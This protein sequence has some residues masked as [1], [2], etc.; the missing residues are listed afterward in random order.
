MTTIDKPVPS[1][2]STHRLTGMN[3]H[4][5]SVDGHRVNVFEAGDGPR[6]IMLVPGIPDSS[7]V[8]RGQVTGLLDAGYRVIAPDLLGQGDSDM[9][10]GA[11]HYT[12]AR[13]QERLWAVADALGARTFHLVGHDRGAY[14]TWAMAAKRPDRVESLVALSTGHPGARQQSGYEQRQLSWYMLRLQFPD[15]EQW[16]RGE[17]EGEGGPWSTFRWLVGH[18]PESDAWIADLERPGAVRAMLDYYRANAH[19]VEATA[20]PVPR[21]SVPVLGVWP[22]GDAY[23]SLEQMARSGEWVDGPWRFETMDGA[24]HFPQLDR[25]EALTRLIVSHT[26]AYGRNP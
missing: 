23:S 15:A 10:A 5:V 21:V 1:G 4:S 8:Y 24:G 13:D 22:T 9:P 7:A 17:S 12:V 14:S 26:E 2:R 6:T 20:S 16:L 19:P 11:E 18:H 3:R 25:P